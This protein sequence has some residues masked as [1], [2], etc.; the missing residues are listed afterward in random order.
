MLVIHRFAQILGGLFARGVTSRVL[1]WVL[2]SKA[3][4]ATSAMAFTVAGGFAAVEGGDDRYEPA[5][6]LR[7]GFGDMFAAN[8]FYWGRTYG[9]VRQETIMTSFVR[10]WGMFNS[11]TMT[12]EFGAVL[13][14]ERISLRYHE[15]QESYNRTENN[16]NFGVVYG[17]Q[18]GLPKS[19]AP[20]HLSLGW[21]SHLF[22]AGL[23]GGLFLATGRKHTLSIRGGVD[24]K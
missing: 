11:E 9:P 5:A 19:A 1:A 12:A 21:D 17:V 3:F 22:A 18:I 2:V 23:E 14:D 4:L 7:L 13:M 6:T 24:L 16:Y 10:R 8:T 20:M 15:P